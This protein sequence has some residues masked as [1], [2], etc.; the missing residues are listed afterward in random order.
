MARI[1]NK[2]ASAGIAVTPNTKPAIS[3]N[4]QHCNPLL[5]ASTFKVEN[6]CKAG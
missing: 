4:G 3:N 2:I 1:K 6:V 5:S